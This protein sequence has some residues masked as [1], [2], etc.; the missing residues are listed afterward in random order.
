MI[1]IEESIVVSLPRDR[2][3]EF[4]ASP[5]N[6]PLWNPAV[7]ESRALGPLEPGAKV[8]QLVEILGRTFRAEYEVTRYE[9]SRRVAYTATAGPVSVHGT[10]EF[11]AERGRTLV[12]W[13]VAGECPSFLRIAKG[14]L[15]ARGRPEMRVCLQNLKR[16][17]EEATQTQP[18]SA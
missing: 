7:R 4:A 18:A 14:F 6:M 12:R 8:E 3:F 11:R 10:M 17:V 1:Q 13:I 2:V 5:E 15:A 16:L 9:P